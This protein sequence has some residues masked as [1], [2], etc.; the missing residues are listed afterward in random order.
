MTNHFPKFTDLQAAVA[1]ERDYAHKTAR[2]D[3]RAAGMPFI[4]SRGTFLATLD[5]RGQA[6]PYPEADAI[7]WR[8]TRTEIEDA[9]ALVTAKYPDVTEVYIA[10]GFDTAARLQD[11]TDGDYEP[12]M[13]SWNVT[14]WTRDE[15]KEPEA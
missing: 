8:G 6:L 10:G 4:R 14:V 3:G 1:K 11:F 15:P 5:A 13:S 9:I 7:E 12:W 2:D